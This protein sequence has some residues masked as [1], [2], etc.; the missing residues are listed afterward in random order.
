MNIGFIFA[1]FFLVS[2]L[3]SI[4]NV[5][6]PLLFRDKVSKG[7][8]EYSKE[9]LQM[10]GLGHRLTHRPNNLSGGE[11]QRVAIARAIV[12]KPKLL[13][14]DEPTANLDTANSDLIFNIF[15]QLNKEGMTI[16]V[17]TH[18]EELAKRAKRII[19]LQDGKIVGVQ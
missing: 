2:A 12:N 18:A 11:M 1:D 9:I 6:L 7:E 15:E 8:F 3:T 16:V 5:E 10:V 19:R 4:E 13:L 14:A 17:A